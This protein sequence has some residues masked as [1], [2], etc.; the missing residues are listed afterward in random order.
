[1]RSRLFLCFVFLLSITLLGIDSSLAQTGWWYPESGSALMLEIQKP[2]YNSEWDPN[3]GVLNTVG[4]VGGRHYLSRNLIL[5]WEVPFVNLDVREENRPYYWECSS[6]T[7]YFWYERDQFSI[8]NPLIGLEQPFG[9]GGFFG[10]ADIRLPLTSESDWPA[11][12]LGMTTSFDRFEAFFPKVY[13]IST[14][15]GWREVDP[16]TAL[17]AQFTLGTSAARSTEG[18]DELHADYSLFVG[19]TAGKIACGSFTGGRFLLS[20]NG[21]NASDRLVTYGGLVARFK[22][23]AFEPGVQWRINIDEDLR[24]GIDYAFG[25]NL[26]VSFGVPSDY[27]GDYW[28]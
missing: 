18:G 13:T 3:R 14:D 19:F 20:G 10:S 7:C 27:S 1:M 11:N 28:K 9:N 2:H 6:Y 25:M 21:G 22:L 15:F 24:Q 12:A 26:A 5:I 23:G 17:N 8:G 4:F 16:K